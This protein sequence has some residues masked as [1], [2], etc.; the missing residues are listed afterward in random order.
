MYTAEQR[1]EKEAEE[2]A[3]M[4][5]SPSYSREVRRRINLYFTDPEWLPEYDEE[6]CPECG[7][8]GA[9]VQPV[10]SIQQKED[11]LKVSWLLGHPRKQQGQTP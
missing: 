11:D 3:V 6:E 5:S 4:C 7:G 2:R 8:S 10:R 1:K 9:A